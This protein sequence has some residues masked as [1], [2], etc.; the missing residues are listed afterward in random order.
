MSLV[1]V[2]SFGETCAATPAVTRDC[3]RASYMRLGVLLAVEDGRCTALL[4]LMAVGRHRLVCGLGIGLLLTSAIL[5]F[6]LVG[7]TRHTTALAS[8][9]E[10]NHLVL[11]VMENKSYWDIRDNPNAPYI[12]HTLIPKGRRFTNYYAPLH[13]SLPNYLV[14]TAGDAR[15]CKYDTCAPDSI[16][17]ENIFHELDSSRSGAGAAWKVYAEDMPVN[18]GTSNSGSYAVRHNPAVYYRNLD[19]TFGDGSCAKNDVPFT[20]L[21][22]DLAAHTLPPFSMIVPNLYDDMHSDRGSP[23]CALSNA[24]QDEIC[25]GDTWLS[26]QL[27]AILS[28]GG[29]NDVTALI[30]W[31]EGASN[32]AGG[33]HILVI[34]VGAGIPPGTKDSRPLSHYGLVNAIADWFSLPNLHPAVPTL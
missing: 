2:L 27:P 10:S 9:G 20:E 12:N 28:D 3:A 26:N 22:A 31:D 18:C 16:N 25:Q 7:S 30:V 11:I 33:G 14:L 8:V 23:P 5:A 15:G 34:E 24:R 32:T 6:V 13:P 4:A 21:S 17:G 19:S 29:A 1:F